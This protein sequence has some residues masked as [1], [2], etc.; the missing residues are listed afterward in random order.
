MMASN[1]KRQ[2]KNLVH[3]LRTLCIALQNEADNEACNPYEHGLSDGRGTS[4]NLGHMVLQ[5]E[6]A[7]K[8]IEENK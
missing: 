2:R 6:Q 1:D 8:M 7:I 5:V 3:D 4:I